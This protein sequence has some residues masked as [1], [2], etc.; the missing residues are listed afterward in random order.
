MTVM[1]YIGWA[2]AALGCFYILIEFVNFLIKVP[3][4]LERIADALEKE[5]R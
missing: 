2:L 4:E 1:F 3:K 5:K